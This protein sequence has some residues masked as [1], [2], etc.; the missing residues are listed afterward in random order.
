MTIT[1]G[2]VPSL[3][4]GS[5]AIGKGLVTAQFTYFIT[6]PD[7]KQGT[8]DIVNKD[9]GAYPT[10]GSGNKHLPTSQPVQ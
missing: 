10:D 2:D 1:D 5:P 3:K 8:A 7:G 9:M 4:S 6:S